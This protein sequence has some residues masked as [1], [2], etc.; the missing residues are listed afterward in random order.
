M[1]KGNTKE[2][3]YVRDVL[4]NVKRSDFSADLST[5]ERR[6]AS[7]Q[8]SVDSTL[9]LCSVGWRFPAP[10]VFAFFLALVPRDLI[11]MCRGLCRGCRRL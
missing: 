3:E 5:E 2:Y 10:C 4:N 1:A 9:L 11:K 6:G 8:S 7:T